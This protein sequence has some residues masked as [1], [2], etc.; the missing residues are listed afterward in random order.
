MR[1]RLTTILALAT[2]LAPS[3][4]TRNGPLGRRGPFGHRPLLNDPGNGDGGNKTPTTPAGKD[5]PGDGGD[6]RTFS[7]ADLDR[8]VAREKGK[9]ERELAATQKRLADLEAAQADLADKAKAGDEA[10]R[11]KRDLE[12]TSKER[13]EHKAA[14]EARTA[15]YHQTLVGSAVGGAL[16]GLEFVGADAAEVVQSRIRGMARVEEGKDGDAVYLVDG[17]TEIDASDTA[18]VQSWIRKRFPSLVKAASGS[19]GPHGRG[20]GGAAGFDLKNLTPAQKIAQ[21]LAS[22]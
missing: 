12:K 15:R 9:A 6:G 11:L 18:A 16:V 2:A 4:V 7:Q 1:T 5:P 3:G 21:G 14:A 13:D 10:G 20:A 22:K 19:G 8:I 17:K